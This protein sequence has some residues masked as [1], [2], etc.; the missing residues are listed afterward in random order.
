MPSLLIWKNRQSYGS[1]KYLTEEARLNSTAN[2]FNFSNDTQAVPISAKTSL[3]CCRA[4][5]FFQLLRLVLLFT[6]NE[7]EAYPKDRQ[8][9]RWHGSRAIPRLLYIYYRASVCHTS[10]HWAALSATWC[11]ASLRHIRDATRASL[12]AGRT[13]TRP[14]VRSNGRLGRGKGGKHRSTDPDWIPSHTPML[15][16][17]HGTILTGELIFLRVS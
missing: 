10:I 9:S 8:G 1:L 14:D 5:V 6:Y 11:V 4:G 13:Y 17:A 3:G 7:R 12:Y 16:R 2:K 15:T